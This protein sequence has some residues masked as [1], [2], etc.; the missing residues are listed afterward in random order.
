MDD[1]KENLIHALSA[2]LN[3]IMQLTSITALRGIT[4][5]FVC[6]EKIFTTS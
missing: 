4:K 3:D 2:Y 5:C 1:M 6:Q